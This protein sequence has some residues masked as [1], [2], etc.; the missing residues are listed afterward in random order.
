[1]PHST[2]RLV[3]VGPDTLTCT[4]PWEGS[5]DSFIDLTQGLIRDELAHGARQTYFKRGSYRG[6]Q[7]RHVGLA[8]KPGRVLAEVR[9]VVAHEFWPHYLDRAEKVSRLDLEVSVKQEPYDHDLA[10]RL[11]RDERE[12]ATQRGRPSKFKLIAE[13]AG[14]TT[15][16]VGTGASRYQGRLYEAVYKHPGQGMEDTW[17]YEV[18]CRRERAQQMAQLLVDAPDADPF[19]AAAV[20]RHFSRRGVPPIFTPTTE[21]VVPP[22]D[23]S[24]TDRDASLRWLGQS[25]RPALHR[26]VA[27]GSYEK[28]LKVLGVDES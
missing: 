9:G 2:T 15:L 27:W 12:A 20:H 1:M 28:A 10:L 13:A 6:I 25:V 11:W 5:V 23:E 3:S 4:A 17:R 14:G 19:V 24:E 21:A 7:T 8:F 22:L 16:Y 26:H 18:Q